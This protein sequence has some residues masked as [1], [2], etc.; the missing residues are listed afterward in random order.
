MNEGTNPTDIG[1]PVVAGHDARMPG[2]VPEPVWLRARLDLPLSRW[3]WLVKW[4]LVIPHLIV[5]LFCG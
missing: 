1:P 4:L 2:P 3:L 5:L